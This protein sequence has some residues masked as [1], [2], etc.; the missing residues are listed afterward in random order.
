[1]SIRH[2]HPTAGAHLRTRREGGRRR[3][4]PTISCGCEVYAPPPPVVLSFRGRPPP[5]VCQLTPPPPPPKERTTDR[6]AFRGGLP[7]RTGLQFKSSLWTASG[8]AG[9]GAHHRTATATNT[10]QSSSGSALWLA[11]QPGQIE[12]RSNEPYKALVAV[13]AAPLVASEACC[14]DQCPAERVSF[15]SHSPWAPTLALPP[16]FQRGPGG[17]SPP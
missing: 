1:M 9:Q 14:C 6:R 2:L 4:V 17:Q 8:P 15:G 3:K 5:L 10:T 11:V 7:R 13:E 16:H 12:H